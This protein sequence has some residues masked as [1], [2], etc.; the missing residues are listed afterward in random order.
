MSSEKM[1][2]S[3]C[4]ICGADGFK[5]IHALI[6]HIQIHNTGDPQYNKSVVAEQDKRIRELFG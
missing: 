4:P 6:N 3:T 2:V 1:D 5:N